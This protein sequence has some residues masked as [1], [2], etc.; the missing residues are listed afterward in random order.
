MCVS[1]SLFFKKAAF[2]AIHIFNLKLGWQHFQNTL[3]LWLGNFRVVQMAGANVPKVV[4][5]KPKIINVDIAET[6]G[7]VEAG[8]FT[9][10]FSLIS[11]DILT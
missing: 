1:A 10:C 8:M 9:P 11:S 3:F 5:F 2:L 7:N 6:F 4:H